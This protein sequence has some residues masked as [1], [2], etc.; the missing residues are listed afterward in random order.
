[1]YEKGH[2]TES[3][4]VTEIGSPK[5]SKK[6]SLAFFSAL[7]STE[8]PFALIISFPPLWSKYS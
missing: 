6:K 7:L 8:I 1:M 5:E 2:L 4:Q 3:I